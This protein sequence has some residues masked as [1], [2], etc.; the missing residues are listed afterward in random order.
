MPA[1]I[2]LTC[3][4]D[5]DGRRI[6][7]NAA[8]VN[9]I[10]QAGG[11][12]LLLPSGSKKMAEEYLRIIDGLLLTGGGDVDPRL[13]GEEPKGGLGRILKERDEFELYITQRALVLGKPILAICRGMQVLN[14][15]AGG[16][17]YQDIARELGSSLHNPGGPRNAVHH[18]VEI[19][20]G[21]LLGQWLEGQVGVN[22]MHHQAVRSLGQG[23]RVSATS[24][25]G[26]IEAIE[27]TGEVFVV[28]VQWH[29]EELAHLYPEQHELF[30]RFVV[31]AD[32]ST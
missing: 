2:G 11:I 27:G 14:V 24:E 6:Y 25:D 1:V 30:K 21:T 3:D 10:L 18:R 19:R 22:S 28:G 4:G 7:L 17:L 12:P 29:P 13:Y 26:V 5:L 31:A 15:A 32:I 8:Y 20:S 16:T 9:A 23:L